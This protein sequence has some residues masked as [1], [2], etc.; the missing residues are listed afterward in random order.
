LRKGV[1]FRAL[2]HPGQKS[3]LFPSPK[4]ILGAKGEIF[5]AMVRD[6]GTTKVQ[7]MSCCCPLRIF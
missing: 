6:L 7:S 2:A 5:L 3:D 1:Y 4:T